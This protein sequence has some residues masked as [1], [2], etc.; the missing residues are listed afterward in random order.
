MA[1]PA[2]VIDRALARTAARSVVVSRLAM[3]PVPPLLI[4]IGVRASACT[5]LRSWVD[6]NGCGGSGFCSPWKACAPKAAKP[7]RAAMAMSLVFM[8]RLL[9]KRGKRGKRGKA[10]L[11]F[12]AGK[13]DRCIDG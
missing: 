9:E 12:D 10:G 6:W 13:A 2:R 1:A 8:V 5:V 4:F 7:E 11:R 3:T